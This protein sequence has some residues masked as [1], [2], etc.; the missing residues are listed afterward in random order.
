MDNLHETERALAW[1]AAWHPSFEGIAI[2]NPDFTFKSVNPQFCEILGVTP[3]ELLNKSFADLTPPPVKEL[4]ILN[5]QLVMKRV[6]PSY[7]LHKS[8]EFNNGRRVNVILLVV[9]VFDAQQNFLF[10]V[11]RILKNQQEGKLSSMPFSQESGTFIS[12]IRE[13]WHIVLVVLS[14]VSI[15]A[16][17]VLKLLHVVDDVPI[18]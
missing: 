6:I 1:A 17:Q 3:G 10:F 4:D 8:Y 5:A 12:R 16:A 11:S 9:G 13:N 2:V 18:K 7:L 14:A 15:V